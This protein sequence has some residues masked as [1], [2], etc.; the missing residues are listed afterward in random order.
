MNN[1]KIKSYS[2]KKSTSNGAP[3]T[4]T[5]GNHQS[6]FS[7]PFY[8]ER[9]KENEN[10]HISENDKPLI[11]NLQSSLLNEVN[12]LIKTPG[13]NISSKLDNKGI[14]IF[15]NIGT[16][17]ININFFDKQIKN[18]ISNSNMGTRK[19]SH[20]SKINSET[21]T[22]TNNISENKNTERENEKNI[23]IKLNINSEVINNNIKINNKS[24][25]SSNINS[26]NNQSEN[27]QNLQNLQNLHNLNANLE[28]YKE[29][30]T[31]KDKQIEE[32]KNELN[33]M[34][35]SHFVSLPSPLP[36]S[37]LKLDKANGGNELCSDRTSQNNSLINKALN[38]DTNNN[39][40]SQNYNFFVESLK[41]R[42]NTNATNTTYSNFFRKSNT[43]IMNVNPGTINANSNNNNHIDNSKISFLGGN[44]S[45]TLNYTEK[46]TTSFIPPRENH[47]MMTIALGNSN[48][49]FKCILFFY[50]IAKSPKKRDY[51]GVEEI[52]QSTFNKI[53]E[54]GLKPRSNTNTI[55]HTNSK[56]VFPNSSISTNNTNTN[57]NNNKN[58]FSN[59]VISMKLNQIKSR[60][61]K[62]LN[63]Y[64]EHII[65]S[66]K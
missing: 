51:K 1:I 45:T 54:I 60:V 5:S 36:L 2:L 31:N 23:N 33:K 30:I 29:I 62:V 50:L 26:K 56:I 44:N 64:S 3:S 65:K 41:G 13:L 28:F 40:N 22:N 43:N 14:K 10:I 66:T 16:K 25:T 52:L 47:T 7:P 38:N 49:L 63:F 15:Y 37:K 18:N 35:N 17:S 48:N 24:D 59:E 34:K 4:S 61:S 9:R 11:A 32:L 27:L 20:I 12:K 58:N 46:E 19:N 57:T 21:N 8:T 39:S 42:K 53:A 55:K 6:N